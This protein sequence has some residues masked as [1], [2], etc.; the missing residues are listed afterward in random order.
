MNDFSTRRTQHAS[1]FGL[2]V[3][4]TLAILAGIDSQALT[5]LQQAQYAQQQGGEMHAKAALSCPADQ[6]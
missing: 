4:V 5:P 1:A 2:A 3:V 6:G